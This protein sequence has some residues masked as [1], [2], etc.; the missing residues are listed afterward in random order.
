MT[1]S[2]Q[3]LESLMRKITEGEPE[4]HQESWGHLF[5]AVPS[6]IRQLIKER[7]TYR[8]CAIDIHASK[9]SFMTCEFH[10]D[11]DKAEQFVDENA[12]RL[13]GGK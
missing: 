11:F 5:A 8:Q 1:Y 6:I 12:N 10:I 13:E 9:N 7:N 4:L 2:I 3:Q